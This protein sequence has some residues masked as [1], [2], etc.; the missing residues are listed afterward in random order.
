MGRARRGRADRG[1]VGRPDPG[2]PRAYSTARRPEWDRSTTMPSGTYSGCPSCPGRIPLAGCGAHTRAG[3]R[4][5]RGDRT[6][7]LRRRPARSRRRCCGLGGV[8]ALVRGAGF[9]TPYSPIDGREAGTIVIGADGVSWIDD[10][11]RARTVRWDDAV[12]LHLGRRTR[13]LLNPSG[14][15]VVMVPWRWR[16]G[17]QFAAAVDESVDDSRRI[18]L[19]EG[20]THYL[21]DPGD[22]ESATDVRWLGSIV[23]ARHDTRPWTSSSTPTDSSA[24][25]RQAAAGEHARGSF[26]HLGRSDHDTLLAA[27]AGN[28]WVPQSD[29][30]SSSSRSA[31]RSKA[32][33]AHA[34]C[35][36][37]PA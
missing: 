26:Q 29:I 20:E 9:G 16:G 17:H 11:E 36:A 31:P 32:A 6:D 15:A 7:A 33:G 5:T 14:A 2:P 4:R 19:G 10:D 22:P 18:R 34:A 23:G 1:R 25:R 37:S 27:D 12:C 13:T 35:C 24:V 3:V 21:T 8:P 28:R 30:D